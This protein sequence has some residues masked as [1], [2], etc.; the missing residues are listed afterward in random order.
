MEGGEPRAV[1]EF[2]ICQFGR[3]NCKIEAGRNYSFI[4]TI[5]AK[6]KYIIMGERGWEDCKLR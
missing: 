1:E 6:P 3:D 5:R 2:L 4:R